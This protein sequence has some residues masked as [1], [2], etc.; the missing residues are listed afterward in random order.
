MKLFIAALALVGAMLL[1][2]AANATKVA[3]PALAEAIGLFC[4]IACTGP[5]HGFNK[6]ICTGFPVGENL[7]I[8]AGHCQCAVEDEFGTVTKDRM[9]VSLDGGKSWIWV[10]DASS[11]THQVYDVQLII[12]PIRPHKVASFRDAI[13]GETV[14]G[15]GIPMGN[16]GSVGT[17][18]HI[19]P[20]W[21][22]ATNLPV[23]GMSG[24]A[25]VGRDGK[26]V[27]MAIY[28]LVP[29]SRFGSSFS[30]YLPSRVLKTLV[31]DFKNLIK[32]GQL[33]S[34]A[35]SHTTSSPATGT[36]LH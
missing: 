28:G 8:T 22:M 17:I 12:V 24:S 15:F 7:V 21:V 35:N 18:V 25:L 36:P 20:T 2:S 4:P 1:S 33:P 27:G 31:D 16:V 11:F 26:V 10:N 3:E 13:L 34:A 29:D 9:T 14:A 30:G 5:A 6:Q 23:G 19:D 32:K